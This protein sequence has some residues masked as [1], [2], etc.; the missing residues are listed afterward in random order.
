VVAWLRADYR[1]AL[2]ASGLVDGIDELAALD[3]MPVRLGEGEMLCRRG[4]PADRLWVVVAGSIAVRDVEKTLYVRGRHDVVGELNLLSEEGLRVYDLVAAELEAELLAIDK[5]RVLAHPAV[6]LLWRNLA[7][8]VALKLQRATARVESLR[9][10]VA[11]DSFILRAYTNEYALSRRLRAGGRYLTDHRVDHAVIWFSDVVNF[12]RLVLQL[13][14]ARAADLVQAFFNAQAEAIGRRGGHVDKFIGDGL[15]AFWIMPADDAA[16]RHEFSERAVRAAI[17]AADGVAR[18]EIGKETL[19]LRVGLHVGDVLSGDFGSTTRHQF[20][21]IGSEVNKAARLEQILEED[22]LEG[23]R[24]LG[25]IRI[26]AELASALAP[27]TRARF[28]RASTVRAKN[29]GR[30]ELFS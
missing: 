2:V 22:V 15:M 24:E 11:N 10:E 29:I 28:P 16:T 17:E 6:A 30:L 7:R 9:E 14:P 18:I 3:P 4:E 12:S 21:L 26:S 8:I 20:T 27:A 13:T 5:A 19:R 23:A 25:P 1:E